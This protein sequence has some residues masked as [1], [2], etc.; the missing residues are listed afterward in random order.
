MKTETANHTLWQDL[1]ALPGQ[2]WLLFGGTF[3]NRFGHFV[4]PFL[5]IYLRQQGHDAGTIGLTLGAYGAGGLFA[6]VIGGYLSDKIG[7][8]PTMLISCG[9]AAAAMLLLS[10][11]KAPVEL[12]AAMFLTGLLGAMYH[13]AA[14]ALISDLVPPG[15]RVR[16]FS[17]QRLAINLGFAAGMATAGFVATQSFL[18]L[19][20]VDA[21]TTLVLGLVVF[22][23][24][25]PRDPPRTGDRSWSGA[26]RHMA[27]NRPF[28]MAAGASFLIAVVF[29][30]MSSSYGLQITEGAGL[31]EKT[32]GLL[33][34]M[35]GV[36]IVL[37]EL[38]LTG[39]T[40]RFRPVHVMAAGYCLAGLGMGLNAFGAE[41]ALLVVSMMIFT[42]GEMIAMPVSSSYMAGLAPD[43]M[44]G[45]YQGVMS[46][47]WSGA[48][49]IGP[50]LGIALH[51]W[52]ASLIWVIIMAVA[53]LA[54]GMMMATQ[55]LLRSRRAVRA[56]DG[57]LSSCP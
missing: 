8:K 42:M 33:M 15:L 32:Y 9:G 12:V 45:R 46:V 10:Q 27:G 1:R 3:V 7:R 49:M 31:D 20:I 5:A 4:V 16:A 19:F 57:D 37:L 51:Q 55:P 52:D 34:A 29:W 22:W 14:S 30:Q 43:E 18:L 56:A 47:M 39:M 13:P 24:I 23:G 53:F 26:L 2:Y 6:G 40:R 17:A 41:M 50:P 38:P 28:K 25:T 35:N 11:A 21:A 54:A 44:R 36:M 48:T